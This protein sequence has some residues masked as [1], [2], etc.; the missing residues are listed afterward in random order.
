[1]V[2]G[3][4]HVFPSEVRASAAGGVDWINSSVV[5]GFALKATKLGV[6]KELHDAIPT[7]QITTAR[8]R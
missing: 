2:Q 4:W 1:M 8:A 7:L 3:V 6:V 5:V